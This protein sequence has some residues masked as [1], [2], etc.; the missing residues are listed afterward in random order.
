MRTAILFALLVTGTAEAEPATRVTV[1]GDKF[2]INGRPTYAGRTWNGKPIEGLLFNSR[3]VQATFDDRNPETATKWTYPDTKAWDPDRNTTE[4]IAEMPGWRKHGLLA[5]TLNLQGGSPEGYSKN[6]PWHNSAVN[7][8]GS[9]DPKYLGRLARVID[10]AD[11]LGMV[12]ILGVYYFGQD[13]RVKDEAAVVAGVDATVD[14]LA[15]KGYANVLLE[16]NN[17]CDVKAYDHAILM[18]DRVHELIERARKR[19][20]EKK[21]PLLVGTS[22]GGGSIPR[23]NVVKSSDFLLLHGNGVGQPERIAEMVRRTRKVDGYRPMPI[24]FNE[25]DHFDFD[26]PANNFAAAVG[27]FASWGYFDY[28]MKGEGFDEGYQS[29]PVNWKT[30]S[31]R[32]RGFFKLL[33]EITREKP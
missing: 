14:W 17:E 13:Q 26:K 19:S 12:V 31:A 4:F 11:E 33:S 20:A 6:Q 2:H 22:Y 15:A 29:V 18:P 5:V 25:D 7:A 1:V 24:L 28:R 32:K 21:R 27:E 10:K 30:S 8:D 16:I 23:P 9:L 3:M